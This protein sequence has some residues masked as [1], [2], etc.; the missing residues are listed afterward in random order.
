MTLSR[1]LSDVYDKK[2]TPS[3]ISASKATN[4]TSN[5]NH[6]RID[7]ECWIVQACKMG[8]IL[9]FPRRFEDGI[10]NVMGDFNKRR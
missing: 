1:F 7:E 6:K 8:Y 5:D 2:T 9:D 10:N 4:E 3:Q